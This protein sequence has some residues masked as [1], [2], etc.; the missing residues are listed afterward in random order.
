MSSSSENADSSVPTSS[1][2]NLLGGSW[3]SVASR[4]RRRDQRSASYSEV[5]HV[6][7]GDPLVILGSLMETLKKHQIPG[8]RLLRL[9]HEFKVVLGIGSQFDVLGASESVLNELYSSVAYNAAPTIAVQCVHNTVGCF[10]NIAIKRSRAPVRTI[11][12][13]RDVALQDLNQQLRS[14]QSE[15]D[16]L[17]HAPFRNHDH[18]VKLLAWGL[19]LDTLED[20]NLEALRI[21]LLVLERA[22]CNLF[23][24][25]QLNIE[26]DGYLNEAAKVKVCFDIGSGLSALHAESVAHGDL[27]PQNILMF[28]KD[29][30]WIAKLCDF[31]L[32]AEDRY[33]K[34]TI[35]SYGGTMGW[36]PK[37]AMFQNDLPLTSG[38]CQPCDIFAYGLLVWSVF[39]LK[40]QCPLTEDQERDGTASILASTAF[41][42]T[43]WI[44][45]A[46]RSRVAFTCQSCLSP[47]P[48]A[49]DGNPWRYLRLNIGLARPIRLL[50]QINDLGLSVPSHMK[51]DLSPVGKFIK[52]ID[53]G[54][55][56]SETSPSS[57]PQD[58]HWKFKAT[59]DYEVF[60]KR[61]PMRRKRYLQL[62]ELFPT[63]T[64]TSSKEPDS[65][66]QMTMV[67]V[68]QLN[69][70]LLRALLHDQRPQSRTLSQDSLLTVYA[71]SC[72]RSQISV[73]V[74]K[75]TREM[76][77]FP[78]I[79]AM[80]FTN[81]SLVSS[82]TIE[83]LAWLCRGEI[84]KH[85]IAEAVQS[86]IDLW[87]SCYM[88][89][90][91]GASKSE[92]VFLL[93]LAHGC[94]PGDP[95]SHDM[96]SRQY[97]DTVLQLEAPHARPSVFRC[98][99]R[100]ILEDSI[101]E[102][103]SHN[104]ALI[105]EV[106]NRFHQ[107]ATSESISPNTRYFMTGH[108]PSD[109]QADAPTTALHDC[110]ISFSYG[111]VE[112]LIRN[113]FL[114]DCLNAQG[115]TALQVVERSMEHMETTRSVKAP[116]DAYR[117]VAL[118][119]QHGSSTIYEAIQTRSSG[120][121][122]VGYNERVGLGWE[123]VEVANS[124]PVYRE[125]WSGSVTL[126]KPTFSL[127]EDRQLALGQRRMMGGEEGQVYYLDLIRFISQEPVMAQNPECRNDQF[128]LF[129]DAWYEEE[130]ERPDP[131]T[132]RSYNFTGIGA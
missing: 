95:A 132:P 99:L 76:H 124:R 119:R 16:T 36:R 93:L 34:E 61:V 80:V 62:A 22:E 117:I 50:N 32:S 6:V 56:L 92:E 89:L 57:L 126:K 12:V 83:T 107:T 46:V 4:F 31:G 35:V 30:G 53:P 102:S 11:P 113:G 64:K 18:I 106:C 90:G 63:I 43:D 65:L 97:F 110:A 48:K 38:A 105:V 77:S 91:L 100:R 17:S 116:S 19:C 72:L 10:K 109:F 39:L 129:D 121:Q 88:F 23:E 24:S 20:R 131:I 70:Q 104:K 40:G 122:S 127:F 13:S 128:P 114:V 75:R 55:Q 123:K 66:D 49:R 94:S 21:P 7:T 29:D 33:N 3:V 68:Q 115:Y 112:Q 79:V 69:F 101:S 87:R 130:P 108:L 111:G 27:K 9:E 8:P 2:S 44:S 78:N 15:I 37:E 41:Q 120:S 58:R 60:T 5:E 28:P 14:A 51:M 25:L 45:P 84:G 71:L 82:L 74:W 54:P 81:S 26:E 67:D 103:N 125:C 52:I 86:G 59:F 73:A 1:L 96:I 118:L 98:F 47:D 42:E 85:E